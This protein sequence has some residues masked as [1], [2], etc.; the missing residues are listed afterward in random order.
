MR[1]WSAIR[2]SPLEKRCV[3]PQVI[4]EAMQF[5]QEKG[6][7][8]NISIEL[9]NPNDQNC[10]KGDPDLLRQVFMNI[11]DNAVKYSLPG[12]RVLVKDWIQRKTG[13]LLITVS[14]ESIGFD[15]DERIFELG[16][17][18]KK[19]SEV[20]SSG[21]G[22]GLYICKLI[23]EKLFDGEIKAYQSMNNV[24]FEIRLPN[25]FVVSREKQ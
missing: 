14:G 18:G 2:K 10:V 19:A 7:S 20:T 17:R 4:I 8:Y 6:N 3:I 23:A 16:V 12:A 1:T 5:F 25:A 9:E 21:S 11:F 13:D 22:L 24:V 15:P